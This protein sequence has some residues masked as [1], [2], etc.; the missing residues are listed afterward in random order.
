MEFIFSKDIVAHYGDPKALEEPV[1]RPRC[2]IHQRTNG[3]PADSIVKSWIFSPSSC[4]FERGEEVL[5]ANP[6]TAKAALDAIETHFPRQLT[7]RTISLKEELR[8]IQM[9]YST[10][11][12]QSGTG[13]LVPQQYPHYRPITAHNST[14]LPTAGP[15]SLQ[16]TEQRLFLSGSVGDG[17][18]IPVTNTGHNT[19]PTPYRPLH[20]NNLDVKNAFLHGSLSETVYMQQPLG[21]RDS[22]HLDHVCLLQRSLYGLKQAPRY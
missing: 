8:V 19:L 7:P 17:K 20:L 18:S 12:E 2:R 14:R 6:K 15:T 13:L 1:P 11:M 9:S 3:I 10:G 21:F 22:Q 16:P 4:P 5:I